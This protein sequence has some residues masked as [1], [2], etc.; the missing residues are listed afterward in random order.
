MPH[1]LYVFA[2][3]P[4]DFVPAGL[5]TLTEGAQGAEASTFANGVR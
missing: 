5:L 3:L 1:G 4:T 2:H